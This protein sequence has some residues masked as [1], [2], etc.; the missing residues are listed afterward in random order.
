MDMKMNGTSQSAG[1]QKMDMV[2]DLDGTYTMLM[3]GSTA[4]QYDTDLK[5]D[6]TVNMDGSDVTNAM[7]TQAGLTENPFPMDVKM[8]VRA[9]W[10]TAP[11]TS[12]ARLWPDCWARP[13]WRTPGSSWI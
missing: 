12:A 11:C 8:E 1:F 7:L 6:F 2:F 9:T 3:Q 5:M 10:P 13:T 4:C